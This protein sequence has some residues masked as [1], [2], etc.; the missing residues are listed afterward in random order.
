MRNLPHQIDFLSSLPD[1]SLINDRC[2]R[3]QPTVGSGARDRC[4][5]FISESKF[6]SFVHGLCFSSC[7]RFLPWL[8]FIINLSLPSCFWSA[9]FI[10]A[11]GKQPIVQDVCS[12][13]K[14]LGF[15]LMCTVGWLIKQEIGES[16]CGYI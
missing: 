4:S 13:S 8:S 10:T 2:G 9:L 5:W 12:F 3:A 11:T 14:T 7:P 16:L 1:I 15:I 6:R